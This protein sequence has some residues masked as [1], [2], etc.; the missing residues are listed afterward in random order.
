MTDFNIYCVEGRHTSDPTQ[1]FMV[2]GGVRCPRDRKHD[3]VGQIHSLQ[4]RVPRA[5][6][7]S[8]TS[9]TLAFAGHARG[10][11]LEFLVYPCADKSVS[12]HRY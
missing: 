1:Q 11:M 5:W 9:H 10:G 8:S 6:Q 2:I 4:A 12:G 7:P 3:L